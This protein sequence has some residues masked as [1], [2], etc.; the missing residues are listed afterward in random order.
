MAYRFPL[1]HWKNRCVT[2]HGFIRFIADSEARD[3]YSHCDS[4]PYD[5]GVS[6]LRWLRAES[7][8]PDR[9]HSAI[10]RLRIVNDDT[11]PWP[12]AADVARFQHY[13]DR[14]VGNPA[15]QWYALLRGTQGDPAAILDCGYVVY[16]DDD[17]WGWVYE[18]N[19]DDRTF[20]VGFDDSKRVTW[21]WSALPADGQFEQEAGQLGPNNY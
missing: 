15:E 18:I 9:L 4:G 1:A 5:L 10:N 12:A 11:G 21:R 17:P 20:S 16:E 8:E 19:A 3:S 14:A 13:I 6:V 7:M 2:T